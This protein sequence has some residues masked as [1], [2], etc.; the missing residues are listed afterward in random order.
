MA[1][2]SAYQTIIVESFIPASTSGRHG[3]VHVRPVK[4]QFYSQQLFVECSRRLVT[5]FP[6]GTKF[7]IRVKLADVHASESE[8]LYSYHGW[9]FEVVFE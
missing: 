7:R 4:G 8:F 1:K 5:D 6:V 2:S 9:P 3:K